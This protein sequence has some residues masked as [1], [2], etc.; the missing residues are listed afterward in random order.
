MPPAAPSSG[1]GRARPILARFLR[2]VTYLPRWHKGVLGAALAVMLIGWGH[3]GFRTIADANSN[4]GSGVQQN[5][6]ATQPAAASPLGAWSRRLGGS[7]LLGFL[8]G[9]IFRTFVKI[10]ASI[11]ALVL[12]G[13][14]L[15]SYFNILNV[16]LTAAETKYK[17]TS[18]WVTGLAGKLRDAAMGHVHSTLGGALGLFIGVRKKNHPL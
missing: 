6:P 12:S 17:D 11:T 8:V 16:D 5:P 14:I 4:T 3:L 2:D 13:I 18:G 1:W 10:M 9:W 7:V 15:L